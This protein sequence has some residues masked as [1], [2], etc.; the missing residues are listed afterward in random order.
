[1]SVGLLKV[2]DGGHCEVPVIL[3]EFTGRESGRQSIFEDSRGC[4]LRCLE[5]VWMRSLQGK[6]EGSHESSSLRLRQVVW[7]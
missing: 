1:M 6:E 2:K 4:P 5:V 3:F 7:C